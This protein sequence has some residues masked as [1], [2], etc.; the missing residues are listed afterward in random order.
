M[1]IKSYNVT[2]EL[3]KKE[4]AFM[5]DQ[6][7]LDLYDLADGE[8]VE[9]FEA[10]NNYISWTKRILVQKVGDLYA[11]MCFSASIGAKACPENDYYVTMGVINKPEE[12]IICENNLACPDEGTIIDFGASLSMSGFK[13]LIGMF[14]ELESKAIAETKD[15]DF[16]GR[17]H[18]CGADEKRQKVY[19][20]LMKLGYEEHGFGNFREWI[21]KIK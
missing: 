4:V 5:K 7:I 11:Y 3:N 21:K 8:Q 18:A 1:T 10:A 14:K 6:R 16:T 13:V 20:Y 2:V 12:I 17:I 19:R 15:N 9:I